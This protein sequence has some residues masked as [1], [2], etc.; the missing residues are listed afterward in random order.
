MSCFTLVAISLERYFAIC[1]PLHSRK[2]QTLSHSYKT[3]IICWILGFLV[4]IPMAVFTKYRKLRHGNAICKE[5]WE[6]HVGH[7]AYSI[8]LDVLL[9]VLP[10]IV[11]SISYGNIAHTLWIG[12]KMEKQE[13]GNLYFYILKKNN[14]FRS[15][16]QRILWQTV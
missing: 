7:K 11:M 5:I 9:L 13:M 8:L 15:L 14:H 16:D 12:M 3:I 1:R 10:V 4:C 6:D 2:W